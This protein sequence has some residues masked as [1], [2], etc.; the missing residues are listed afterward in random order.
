MRTIRIASVLVAAGVL[1]TAGCEYNEFER[2]RAVGHYVRGQLLADRGDLD[3]A[4]DELARAVRA[5]P[6]LSVAHSAVGDIHRKRGDYDLARVSY[7]NACGA[8]PYAFRPHYNLGV[9]YQVLAHAAKTF[10]RAE[11]C[12][13]E[14]V[15]VYLR[16]I[17]LEP[18]DFDAGLNLSACYF[19]LG[20]HALAEKYCRAAI[21]LQPDR[22]EAYSNLGVIL[23]SQDRLNEAVKAYMDSLELD[24]HQPKLWLN[25]GAA[26]MRQGRLKEARSALEMATREDPDSAEAWAQL[27]TCH[28]HRKEYVQAVSVYDKAISLDDAN[29][30]AHR[31]LGVVYMT[32]F[33]LTRGTDGL[34]REKALA[35]WHLSL[36]IDPDQE[37]VA[38]LVRKYSPKPE[39]PGPEL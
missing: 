35:A 37:D 7:E 27:G 20:K 24:V 15:A 8:N 18:D 14:A 32:Q 12:L 30:A 25:L 26:Y 34:L 6:D 22:P 10:Q 4:L 19:S 23:D 3:A 33:L 9:V 2:Q 31:G 11:E 38:H 1:A 5:D 21:A 39:A 36:G 16:A 29:A 13:R 28:Y 17:S